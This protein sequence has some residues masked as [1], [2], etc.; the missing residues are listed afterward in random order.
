MKKLSLAFLFFVLSA[1]AAQT[2]QT[3]PRQRVE[4][5]VG[6]LLTAYQNRDLQGFMERVSASYPD[7]KRLQTRLMNV[8]FARSDIRI[9][10]VS[11]QTVFVRNKWRSQISF[12]MTFTRRIDEK[13]QS[14]SL[15]KRFAVTAFFA[16]E[17]GE[18]KLSA[19]EEEKDLL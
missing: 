10:D 9:S 15:A 13:Q 6:I 14:R 7:K 8:F 11:V 12:N 2:V 3:T 19:L 5:T 1:C 17:N 16:D 4:D 18:M